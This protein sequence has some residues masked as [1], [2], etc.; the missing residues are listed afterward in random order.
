MTRNRDDAVATLDGV[1]RTFGDVT[2]LDDVTLAL[3][4]GELIGM[5]GPNGAGKSTLLSLV[6]GIRR[7][8]SGTVRLFGQDPRQ[9]HAR[10]R[11]GTTPQET[12]LPPTLRV[13]EVI[14]F[15]AGHYANPL[16]TADV[17][18]M[19]DLTPLSRRQTG[20]LSG[21]QKRRLSVALSIVGR[22]ALVLLDEPTTGLDIDARKVLWDA[23]RAYH[24]HGST[25]V[26]TS[27]YLEEIEA[28]AERVV[29]VDDGRVIADDHL[30]AIVAQVAARHVNVSVAGG[31]AINSGL[32]P[33]P[34][35]EAVWRDAQWDGERASLVVQ[36]SDALVRELVTSGVDFSDLQVR[37]ATLEEAFVAMTG[38]AHDQRGG[39]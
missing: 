21:G 23:V 27:H 7:P 29:V 5:L 38:V 24:S 3:G 37:G 11:L 14:D 31:G 30:S 2:A 20:G 4:E 34:L 33:G 9:A 32:A 1:T 36:D 39:A 6:S 12:G 26:V 19:F 22:P 16:A 35:S 15:V 8:S 28:L 10:A 18:E 25:V 13:A 17:L